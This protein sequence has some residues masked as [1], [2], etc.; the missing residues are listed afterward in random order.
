MT[1]T[2][3]QPAL[4]EPALGLLQVRRAGVYLDATLGGGG[5][6]A[7]ILEAGAGRLIGLDLDEEALER[8]AS[9]LAKFGDRVSLVRTGFQNLSGVLEDQGLEGLDGLVADLGLSS[10]QLASAGRGFSFQADGPLD[11]RLDRRQPLTAAQLLARTSEAGLRDILGRLGEESQAGRIARAIAAERA[12]RPIET[13][14]HLA[15]VVARAKSQPRRRLHPA[16]KTFLAL[17]LAVN[18]ELE[19]LAALLEQLPGAL[20]TGGRAVIVAYHSLEDRLVKDFFRQ[21]AKGCLCPPGR[22]CVCGLSPVFRVL[23]SKPVRPSAAEVAANPRSRSARL[24]AA[25]RL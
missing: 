11:M 16:T 1:G 19:N 13:T 24:R 22:P 12:R 10:D 25:E 9:R 21:K 20:K 4:L 15:E 14:A 18:R 17:R 2:R 5:Y 7:A 3:H 6:A 8:T 23:T